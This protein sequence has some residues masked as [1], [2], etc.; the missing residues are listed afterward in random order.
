MR[1][2]SHFGGCGQSSAIILAPP[3][4]GK[5]GMRHRRNLQVSIKSVAPVGPLDDGIRNDAIES[6]GG[7]NQR[8][9]EEAAL[10]TCFL[11][12]GRSSFNAP[13]FLYAVGD[14]VV[15][16][17]RKQEPFTPDPVAR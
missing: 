4:S 14:Q 7:E 2:K 3:A 13:C 5:F 6:D 11:D 9:A 10:S 16:S 8:K 17:L 1:H 12:P 15:L